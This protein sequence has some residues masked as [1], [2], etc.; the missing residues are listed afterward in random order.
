MGRKEEKEGRR[1][2]GRKE[3]KERKKRERDATSQKS[4]YDTLAAGLPRNKQQKSLPHGLCRTL[5][6]PTFQVS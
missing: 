3:R 6:V 2:R 1:E 5:N 4:P